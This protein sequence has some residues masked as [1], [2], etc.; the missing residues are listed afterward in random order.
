M[1]VTG[2]TKQ[3][4]EFKEDLISEHFKKQHLPTKGQITEYRGEKIWEKK[5]RDVVQ[6]GKMGELIDKI[7]ILTERLAILES[8]CIFFRYPTK[9]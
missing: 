6:N 3:Q 1:S 5:N 9:G 4:A 2:F 8:K 7:E